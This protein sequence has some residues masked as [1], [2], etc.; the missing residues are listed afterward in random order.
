MKT[1]KNIFIARILDNCLK[2]KDEISIYSTERCITYKELYSLIMQKS[3]T[4]D[5]MGIFNSCISLDITDRIEYIITILSLMDHNCTFV[6]TTLFPEER[7][8]YVND[9]SRVEY[10]ITDKDIVKVSDGIPNL[11][12]AYIMFTS[13]STGLPKGVPISYTSLYNAILSIGKRLGYTSGDTFAFLTTSTFDISLLE[14]LLPLFYGG[15]VFV[16]KFSMQS[17]PLELIE[18][19]NNNKIEFIQGTPTTFKFLLEAGWEHREKNILIG[20]EQFDPI[21]KDLSTQ[22]NHVYNMYGPTEATIWVT[23]EEITNNTNLITCGRCIDNVEI[24]ILNNESTFDEENQGEVCI[25]GESVFSGYLNIENSNTFIYFENKKFY[26][27][28][29]IGYF[30]SNG[31][32]VIIGRKDEQVK[33]DGYRIEL[34]EIEYCLKSIIRKTSVSL[35]VLKIDGELVVFIDDKLLSSEKKLL[36]NLLSEKLPNY[37]LPKHYVYMKNLPKNSSGKLVRKSQKYIENF[38]KYK[39]N[40]ILAIHSNLNVNNI[41]LTRWIDVT[42]IDVDLDTNLLKTGASS[43]D[44][45]MFINRVNN[46]LGL[47]IDISDIFE[48]KT[49]KKINFER[50]AKDVRLETFKKSSTSDKILVFLGTKS[51]K[52]NSYTDMINIFLKENI[53]MIGFSFQNNL[54]LSETILKISEELKELAL[55]NK[56]KEIILVGYSLG[57]NILH[58]VTS[59]YRKNIFR[60]TRGIIIDSNPRNVDKNLMANYNYSADNYKSFS[61][62][63]T[64]LICGAE[65]QQYEELWENLINIERK[66]SL[67][68]AHSMIMRNPSVKTLKSLILGQ[69]ND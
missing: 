1:N 52:L 22:D 58:A 8:K 64:T 9:V 47:S 2:Y 66:H 4:L 67:N 6:P 44:Y 55:N 29:D 56:E 26:K 20:G 36:N 42:G 15:S 3:K 37:M 41:L 39:A 40:A 7:K 63:P 61:S 62:L 12:I 5:A 35:I 59:L 18:E 33:I 13:G 34:G 60:N 46:E 49:L 51:G 16:S 14:I 65:T 31:N 43:I 50:R 54:N 28:G 24:K 69:E 48:H 53:D 38:Q 57:G 68:I 27:T 45:M 11:D 21:L 32:L 23:V 30:D 10:M 17:N 25:S 19:I